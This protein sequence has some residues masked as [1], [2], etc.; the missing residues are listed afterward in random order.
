LN[1]SY[2]A[3]SEKKGSILCKKVNTLATRSLLLFVVIGFSQKI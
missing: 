3:T 2:Y 1:T